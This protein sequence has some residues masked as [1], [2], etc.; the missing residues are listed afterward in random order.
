MSESYTAKDVAAHKDETSGFWI[1]IDNGVYDVTSTTLPFSP[2]AY[3][4]SMALSPPHPPLDGAIRRYERKVI[5]NIAFLHYR[6]SR[7]AS[8]WCQDPQASG[9]QGRLEAVLEIPRPERAPQIWAE[10]EDWRF[11]GDC[12]VVREEVDSRG[13][14]IGSTICTLDRHGEET[15]SCTF[16]LSCIVSAG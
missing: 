16:M 5:T 12:Q 15:C 1:T 8:R 13:R 6:I 11:E 14:M 10:A 9:R 2:P 3:R 7:R 4:Y